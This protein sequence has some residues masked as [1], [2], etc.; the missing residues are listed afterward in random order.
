MEPGRRRPGQ[1]AHRIALRVRDENLRLRTPLAALTLPPARRSTSVRRRAGAVTA[2]AAA[3]I[4]VP[5]RRARHPT[6]SHAIGAL[7]AVRRT[8]RVEALVALSV[9][10]RAQRRTLTVLVPRLR[11]EQV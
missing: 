6:G 5:G 8:R 11:L 7:R 10:R 1:C 2:G 9:R 4:V 3:A